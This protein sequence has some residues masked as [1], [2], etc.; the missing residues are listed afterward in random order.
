LIAK[1]RRHRKALGGGMRQAGILAAA[2]LYALEHNVARLADDHA[3]AKRLADGFG[4]IPALGVVAPDTNIVWVKVAP[5]TAEAFSGYLA[6]EGFGITG[7]YGGEAQ[8]W[9]T[10]LDVDGTA[11]DRA[12]AAAERFF[13]RARY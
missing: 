6:S 1:A 11:V 8:R 10:H 7:G 5:D 4:K 2:G 13:E 9:V 12:I 3:N